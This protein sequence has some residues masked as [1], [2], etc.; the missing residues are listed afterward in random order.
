VGLSSQIVR[1]VV[2]VPVWL[3]CY[4]A[5]WCPVPWTQGSSRGVKTSL[6]DGSERQVRP[7]QL[8]HRF[9]Y[10]MLNRIHGSADLRPIERVRRSKYCKKTKLGL[11]AWV[12]AE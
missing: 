3:P 1:F 2:T 10:R 8:R 5:Q 9:W 11:L 12:P 4:R 7:V 6:F